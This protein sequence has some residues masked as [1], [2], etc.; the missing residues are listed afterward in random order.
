[1][2]EQCIGSQYWLF[3][4]HLNSAFQ[5]WLNWRS[6]RCC[7][8]CVLLVAVVNYDALRAEAKQSF[9][10]QIGLV[11]SYVGKLQKAQRAGEKALDM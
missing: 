1:M 9:A 6:C 7:C 8:D 4:N 10:G 2:L 3:I 5:M 11:R